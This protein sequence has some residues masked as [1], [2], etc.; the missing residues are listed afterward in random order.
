MKDQASSLRKL[1]QMIDQTTRV[2]AIDAETFLAQIPRP[3]PFTAVAIVYPD[4]I[5]PELP[6]VMDWISG[7][8]Q[9]SPRACFWDQASLIPEERIPRTQIRLKF[10]TPVR[11]EAGLTP[12]TI[13]PAIKNFDQIC[14]SDEQGRISYLQH[15]TRSLK[16]S[17]E[18]W[19]SIK[20]SELKRY[21]PIVHSTDAV[22]VVIPQHSEAIIR[23]YEL[24]KSIHL[25]GYFSPVGLLD[26]SPTKPAPEER[27]SKRIKI[28]AKQFLALDLVPAGMVL[29]N[30]TYIPP[31]TET[32]LRTRLMS[33]ES[34]SK[35]FLYCLSESLIYQLPGM[36]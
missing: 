36:F 16:S 8:M 18:V 34:A 33:V 15:L 26:F 3:C 6:P 35:D 7:L 27:L 28:V 32:N 31:E 23:C 17:S 12:L 10:P 5:V 11:V 13:L 30:C 2:Q 24:V 22:C 29:S 9:F 25:S 20:A 21:Y 19:I 1:K 4:D 14:K